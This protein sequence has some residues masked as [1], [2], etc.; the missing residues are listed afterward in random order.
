MTFIALIT[1]PIA[2][3]PGTAWEAFNDIFIK[4]VVMFIV[5]INVLR[6]RKRLMGMIWL[7]LSVG[8]VFKLHSSRLC[9]G[10][11]N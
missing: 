5:M 1:M 9:I 4:A 11:A 2:K 10:A 3:S 8:F 7:S 6:T